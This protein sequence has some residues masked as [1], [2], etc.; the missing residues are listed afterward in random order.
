MWNARPNALVPSSVAYSVTAEPRTAVAT[1]PTLQAPAWQSMAGSRHCQK[2]SHSLT[3]GHVP[4]SSGRAAT[5]AV[6]A[7]A[8]QKHP[9]GAPRAADRLP[10]ITRPSRQTGTPR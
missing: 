9:P 8:G 5:Y 3:T 6:A 4:S 1:Y 7:L 2:A 10:T